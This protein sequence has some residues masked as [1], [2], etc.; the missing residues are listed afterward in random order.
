[1]RDETIEMWVLDVRP[2]REGKKVIKNGRLS[3][4]GRQNSTNG[5]NDMI[6]LAILMDGRRMD[7]WKCSPPRRVEGA[8]RTYWY[9]LRSYGGL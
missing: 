5:A 6:K 3:L 7:T 9:G 1:M 8:L 4:L 2:E